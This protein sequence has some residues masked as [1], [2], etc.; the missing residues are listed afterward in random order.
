MGDPL[1]VTASIAGLCGLA[2]QLMG[3]TAEYVKGV[4]D[5]PKTVEEFHQEATALQA[6]LDDLKSYLQKTPPT[7]TF[8]DGSVMRVAIKNC[9]KKLR[10]IK[11]K[12]EKNSISNT[13][14]SRG[15][16]RLTW[17][18]EEKGCRQAT[19]S[20]HRYVSIFQFPL[21]IKGW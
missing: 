14:V 1:S 6:V 19:E 11:G 21:I 10:E 8:E 9:E 2:I 16:H 13:R 18:F 20:L 4:K 17:P 15:L 12:L 7:N 3:L 5:A